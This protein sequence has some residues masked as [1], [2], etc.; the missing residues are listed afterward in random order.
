MEAELADAAQQ[1]GV[2]REAG[3]RHET[4]LSCGARAGDAAG[5]SHPRTC[6]AR[7]LAP[8]PDLV[9][10]ARSGSPCSE[11]EA[12]LERKGDTEKRPARRRGGA[13]PVVDVRAQ[14]LVRIQAVSRRVAASS[15]PRGLFSA[16]VAA[17]HEVEEIDAAVVAQAIDGPVEMTA[18]LAR[19]FDPR[20]LEELRHRAA[21]SLG[22]AAPHLAIVE[23][24]EFDESAP[25]RRD[26]APAEVAV[27]PIER[28]G[29]WVAALIFVP[30]VPARAP[31]LRL[32]YA[33]ANQA[34]LQLDRLLT[35]REAEQR[36]LGAVLESM[37]QA[38]VVLDARLE[39]LRSNRAARDLLAQLELPLDGDWSA[40]LERLGLLRAVDAVRAG[41]E[42]FGSADL[43][44]PG[45]RAL[46]ATVSPLADADGAGGLVLVL[47]DLTQSRRLER[48]LA[49]SEK[50]SSLGQLISG[51]AHELN[52]PL[53]S[54]L[55]YAQLLAAS[56]LAADP[57]VARRLQ[58]LRRDAERCQRIVENLLA[59][60][61]KRPPERRA[62]SIHQIIEATIALVE[63]SLRVE[64]VTVRTSLDPSVPAIEGDPHE[65]Q[66]ALLNLLTNA[67]DALANRG[68][69]GEIHVRSAVDGAWVVID[70]ADNGPGIPPEMAERVFD[71]FFTTKPEGRGTGLGLAIVYGAVTS[72]GGTVEVLS[73]V[74]RGA[75]VRIRLPAGRRG[76][77]VAPADPDAPRDALRGR[78][79]VIDDEPNVARMVADALEADGH[80]VECVADGPSALVRLRRGR[81]DA[82]LADLRMPGMDG[83]SLVEA[84]RREHPQLAQRVVL[85]TGDT[86]SG[87]A[88]RVAAEAGVELLEKPFDLARLRDCVRRRVSVRRG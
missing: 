29:R 40:N 81:F 82:I 36:R 49:Q 7:A 38:V 3:E 42:P 17:L 15:T 20:C 4:V 14:E 26:V 23:L 47:V 59:F 73:G 33:A 56:P 27:V 32:L 71:P 67:K 52:N 34:T 46:T 77:P 75:T 76:E 83:A 87:Q 9:D 60:A 5:K 19:A 11:H 74:P 22:C 85:A 84:I 16:L 45:E 68:Q 57:E 10:S 18:Y 31:G 44:L 58:V 63:Y 51:T 13:E 65:L 25:V 64:G 78:V 62:L 55:G 6:V 53:A 69:P 8:A 50:M 1:V 79:L 61:R 72:H 86:V 70:V 39:H 41:R 12:R 37:P 66:Q 21:V 28:G 54:V 80:T 88:E 24:D 35:A 48:R 43:E 30:A 2:E